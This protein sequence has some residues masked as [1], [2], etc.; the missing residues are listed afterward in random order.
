MRSTPREVRFLLDEHYPGRL[1]VVLTEAGPDT[2]AV[3]DRD[4]LRGADD[5]TV[6]RTATEE[7]R[8]VVTEDVTTFTIAMSRLPDH[9][10]VVFCHHERFPRNGAGLERLR[11]ALIAFS[12]DPPTAAGHAGFVWWLAE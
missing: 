9:S 6:L 4:D 11:Q 10:G 2:V 5:T 12:A 7:R 3:V 8:V 1:A